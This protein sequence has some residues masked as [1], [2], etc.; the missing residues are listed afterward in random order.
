M[1]WGVDNGIRSQAAI[2]FSMPGNQI[3]VLVVYATTTRAFNPI[4]VNVFTHMA[5]KIEHGLISLQQKEELTLE[6]KLRVDA[7]N[8]VLDAYLATIQAMATAVE[9]RDAFTAGH[10]RRT[11]EI[12]TAIGKQMGWDDNRVQGL[13][14]AAAIHDI[15][16]IYIDLSILCKA[17]SLNA[18]EWV[19]V[20]NHVITGYNIIK[21]IPFPWPIA[22]IVLQHH[23]RIDGSGYP[24]GLKGNQILP[25]AN[26]LIIADILDAIASDRP[27]RKA[28]P[29][30]VVL[31]MIESDAGKKLEQEAVHACLSVYRGRNSLIDTISDSTP[32]FEKSIDCAYL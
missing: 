28:I 10:Q 24:Y 29:L 14:L 26:V 32:I 27:Y 1:K 15:G 7:Q 16:K 20:K 3:G 13:R 9:A 4:A 30:Q 8:Q 25:E 11:K 18:E 5:R 21:Q 12:A 19:L 6:R 17:G 22:D 23:E 31:D 2:P